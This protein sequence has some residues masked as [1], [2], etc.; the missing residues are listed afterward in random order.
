MKKAK[1]GSKKYCPNIFAATHADTDFQSA[2]QLLALLIGLGVRATEVCCGRA[3]KL[4]F[5]WSPWDD[6]PT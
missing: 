5:E 4:C 1:S 6:V 3:V 2:G